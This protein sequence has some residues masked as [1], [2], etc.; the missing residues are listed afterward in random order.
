M[1]PM[2]QQLASVVGWARL[3]AAVRAPVDAIARLVEPD[4]R[5]GVAV[6]VRGEHL[7]VRVRALAPGGEE[8]PALVAEDGLR[9]S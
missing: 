5:A 4:L 3:V 2:M 7:L 8:D 1:P 6:Q 9:C